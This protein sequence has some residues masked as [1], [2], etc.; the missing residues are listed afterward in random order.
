MPRQFYPPDSPRSGPVSEDSEPETD[1]SKTHTSS[2][3]PPHKALVGR[4]VRHRSQVTANYEIHGTCWICDLCASE[5]CWKVPE[6]EREAIERDG[7]DPDDSICLCPCH[8][9]EVDF[10]QCG[11]PDGPGASDP[12]MRWFPEEFFTGDDAYLDDE[13]LDE[14]WEDVAST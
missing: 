9:Y 10:A 8:E 2:S 3:P 11:H 14:W 12:L 7:E 5:E 4:F 6:E 13:R 1:E